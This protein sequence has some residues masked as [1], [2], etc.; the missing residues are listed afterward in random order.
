MAVMSLPGLR[1]AAP[2]ARAAS[3]RPQPL[4]RPPPRSSCHK[5][6]AR[7]QTHNGYRY[8]DFLKEKP[9]TERSGRPPYATARVQVPRR[10]RARETPPGHRELEQPAAKPPPKPPPFPAEPAKPSPKSPPPPSQQRSA[11]RAPSA[12]PQRRRRAPRPQ[13]PAARRAPR[14]QAPA[15]RRPQRRQA[16]P[17]PGPPIGS[18]A[19]SHPAQDSGTRR[20]RTSR[21]R[22]CRRT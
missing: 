18:R 6:G 12:W 13:A 15:A 20:A 7:P 8:P 9:E 4:G 11:P 16:Q 22:C 17:P 10:R 3:R 14:P 5:G 1:T 19:R 21:R 2:A